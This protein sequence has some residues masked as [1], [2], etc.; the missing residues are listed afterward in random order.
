M[1]LTDHFSEAELDVEHAPA[2]VIGAARILC[3]ELL[4][5]IRARFGEI[6]V[7]SGYRPPEHNAAVGGKAKSFHLYQ[8]GKAA[9][10]FKP[11]VPGVC[12]QEVFDWIRLSSGLKFDKVILEY[13]PGSF[14]ERVLKEGSRR[15]CIHIQLH[16]NMAPRRQAFIGET[17]A[18][19]TYLPVHVTPLEVA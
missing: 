3:H 5:P 12:L 11:L 7:T 9:A 18:G 1:K 13:D 19:E 4:E 17:G 6:G 2:E 8:D 14:E 16:T 15:K 10:D